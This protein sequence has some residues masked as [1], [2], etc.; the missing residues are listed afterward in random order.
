MNPA[1]ETANKLLKAAALHYKEGMYAP[2]L[3][4]Y[5]EGLKAE[6]I[7]ALAREHGIDVKKGEEEQLLQML[8]SLKMNQEIPVELFATVAAIYAE[9]MTFQH[10]VDE[11]RMI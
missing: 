9:V 11:S 8:S 5:G 1:G 7:V 2:V 3:K 6:K 4:A 10:N